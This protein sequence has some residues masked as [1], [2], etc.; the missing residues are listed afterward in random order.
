MEAFQ[1][2]A[3]ALFAG[4][5]AVLQLLALTLFPSRTEMRRWTG[6]TCAAIGWK[7]HGQARVPWRSMASASRRTCCKASPCKSTPFRFPA[8]I[9]LF[10]ATK[11]TFKVYNFLR[12]IKMYAREAGKSAESPGASA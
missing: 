1:A 2:S 6:G 8:T 5:H 3:K 7:G 10:Q 12:V 4:N 11:N 9:T